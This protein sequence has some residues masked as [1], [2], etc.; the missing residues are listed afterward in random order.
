MDENSTTRIHAG[1]SSAPAGPHLVLAQ[2]LRDLRERALRGPIDGDRHLARAAAR[3]EY[4]LLGD[5]LPWDAREN[6]DVMRAEPTAW[7][8]RHAPTGPP[9]LDESE[10]LLHRIRLL[11]LTGPDRWEHP[12]WPG[13]RY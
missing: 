1:Q 8:L 5:Q 12:H 13:H 2:L 4:D 11:A 7:L 9:A 6:G 3:W 10:E